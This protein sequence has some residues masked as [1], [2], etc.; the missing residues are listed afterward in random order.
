M[1][2]YIVD[3]KQFCIDQIARHIQKTAGF[4]L[5]GSNTD[6]L[7]ALAAVKSGKVEIDLLFLDIDMPGIDG[8]EFE[9]QV[10]GLAFV[11]FVSGYRKYAVDAFE[12]DAKAYLVKPVTYAKFS[13]AVEKISSI[14]KKEQVAK[15]EDDVE[16]A[17]KI[18]GKNNLKIVRFD[19]IIYVSAADNY[20]ILHLNDDTTLMVNITM[21][22]LLETLPQKFFIRTHHSFAVNRSYASRIVGNTV[23]MK[24]DVS[25]DISRAYR[26][27]VIQRFKSV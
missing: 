4:T 16:F 7:N 12:G 5:V 10:R 25:V 9:R 22:K 15:V 24:N 3:D 21:K 23:K 13:A 14:I 1:K 20:M 6:P 19:S 11:I 27:D 18:N 2:C 8:L 17:V 26:N